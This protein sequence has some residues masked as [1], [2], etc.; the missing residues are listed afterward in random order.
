MTALSTLKYR[1]NNQQLYLSGFFFFSGMSGL[2]Y[3]VVWMCM[4]I[5]VFGISLYAISTIVS[6]FMGGLAIG[7]WLA[8]AYLSK[9]KISLKL[10]AL[11]E[12][13]IGLSAVFAT[14]VIQYFP[15]LYS[16]IA[17]PWYGVNSEWTRGMLLLS[18]LILSALA[19]SIPTILMGT[20]LPILGQFM[21]KEN[22]RIGG[23]LALLYGV[24]TIGAV[25]GVI[26]TGFV[27][28][29]FL[30]ENL[31]VLIAVIINFL[32]ALGAFVIQTHDSSDQSLIDKHQLTRPL[33]HQRLFLVIGAGTG[34]CAL[35]YEILWSR[36]SIFLVGSSVYAFST[37]LA[38]YLLGIGV[39]SLVSTRFIDN[40][41]R[42]RSIFGFAQI[43][44]GFTGIFSLYTFW[45]LGLFFSAPEYL[46]SPLSSSND[47]FQFFGVSALVVFPSTFLMGLSF[48]ILGRLMT[49]HHQEFSKSVGELYAWNT[50]GGVIGCLITG[51]VL[52]P[53]VGT[54]ATTALIAS[55][56]LIIGVTLVYSEMKRNLKTL[57]ILSFI[58]LFFLLALPTKTNII[59]N[60]LENRLKRY[61][62]QVQLM[63]HREEAAGLLT[64]V[65]I[66]QGSLLLINGV[67]T[68]GN[69]IPGHVMAHLPLL[70]HPDPKRTAVI[71]FGV[72]NTFRAAMDHMKQ[73]DAVELMPGVIG[74]FKDFY[75]ESET[76][77]KNPG[78]KVIVEDGRHHILM[79]K[80]NYDVIIVD[81]SPPIFSAGTVNLYTVDFLELC[82]KRLTPNGIMCLWVPTPCFEDDFW[83][84]THG[85]SK[86]YPHVFVWAK[87]GMAGVLVMGST[88]DLESTF[89][90]V[91]ERIKSR[92]L[93]ESKSWLT[94][95]FL[96]DAVILSDIDVSVFADSFGFVTDN[97]PFTEFPLMSFIQNKR[98]WASNEF[99][100]R[101]KLK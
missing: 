19:L 91:G 22:N 93:G 57:S 59:L 5:R 100:S 41:K 83:R 11:L 13:G 70:L 86:V 99:I 82:Q 95:E 76:Y 18:R 65:A 58:V 21:T 61:S 84:I 43:M 8:S 32:I 3:Q 29:A 35:S 79:T 26:L 63:F 80:N 78:A 45:K 101:D 60:V 90:G 31:S 89:R 72:G 1:K 12:L 17:A 75:S 6:V 49:S 68:S 30:G 74:A 55:L 38:I 33:N 92:S 48:P 56:S 66:P 14:I 46:Y 88:S 27:S 34:F 52:V 96:N 24:N 44:L 69:G 23:N 53:L 16:T 36:I 64:G 15:S 54:Q 62:E 50:I 81:A 97:N 2:I 9:K 20:T 98:F 4:F 7:S 28:L 94:E 67:I 10:Y 73:V 77:L 87:K 39:G 51:Y 37:V 47:L 40:F 42:P 71:C 25:S 85:F